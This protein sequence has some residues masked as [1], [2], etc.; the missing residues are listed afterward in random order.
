LFTVE[1]PSSAFLL[2]FN[3]QLKSADDIPRISMFAL[4][5]FCINGGFLIRDFD[6]GGFDA[7]L[8]DKPDLTSLRDLSTLLNRLINET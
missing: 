1:L 4:A 7:F 6:F 3:H 8:K 2:I 5:G